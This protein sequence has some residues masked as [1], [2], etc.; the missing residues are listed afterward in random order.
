M[1]QVNG[2]AKMSTPHCSHIFQP[3][4]MKLE[5]KKDIR[6][7]T[8][9]AKFGWCGTTGRGCAYGVNFPLLFVFYLS[10]FLYSCS[11]LQITPEDRSR[12]FMA[13]NACFHVRYPL[14][15]VSIIKNNILGSKLPKNMI[16]GGLNRH[17]KPNLRNFRIAISRKVRTWSTRNFKGN[18]RCTNGLRGWS[19]ITKL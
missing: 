19:S 9:Q 18:F 13:Q 6:D 11:R 17:F 14:L 15:W 5:T 4:L 16:F 10:F 1:C 2:M 12:P 8:P 3:I 7:T